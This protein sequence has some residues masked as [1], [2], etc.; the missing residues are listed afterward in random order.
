MRLRAYMRFCFIW[1]M[2]F[3]F[4]ATT[5]SQSNPPLSFRAAVNYLAGYQPMAVTVGDF[6]G[7]GK[8]DLALLSLTVGIEVTV[9]LGNGD[10]TFQSPLGY[11]GPPPG[12]PGGFAA[13]DFNGDG[14]LDLAVVSGYLSVLLGNGDGTFRAGV[15]YPDCALMSVAV[16]DFNGDGKLDLVGPDYSSDNVSV[17]M[18]NGDGTFQP[19]VNYPTFP[20]PAS[21]GVGDFNG[22]GKLD[23]AVAGGTGSVAVLLGNGDG[24]F[25]AAANYA[26]SIN[27]VIVIVG[28]FNGDGKLDLAVSD[29]YSAVG[30]LPGNGDGTFQLPPVY[31]SSNVQIR[32]AGDFNGDGKL[33]LVGL[34]P[35]SNAVSVLLGNGDGTFQ[36]AANFAVGLNPSSVAVGDFNGDGQPDLAVANE[37]GNNTVPVNPDSGT[38]SVL[39]NTTKSAARVSPASLTFADQLVGTTSSAQ[40]VTLT[41]SGGALLAIAS[42]G[43][44]LDFA[45]TN[46][47]GRTLAVG[48]QCTISVTFNPGGV[49]NRGGTLTVNDSA[50]DSPETVALSGTGAAPSATLPVGV[51]FPAQP[52]GTTSIAGGMPLSNLGTAALHISSIGI[53]GDFSQSNNCGSSVPAGGSCTINVFFKP[54]ATGTRQGTLTVIDDSNGISGSTQRATLNGTGEDFTVVSPSGSSPSQTV[55]PGQ[56]ATYT[57]NVGGEGALDQAVTFTCTGAPSESTCLVSPNAVT[58]LSSVM[59]I[60]VTVTTTAPSVSGPFSRLIPPTPPLLPRQS[61]LLMIVLVVVGLAWMVQVRRQPGVSQRSAVL[62]KLAAGLLL[63]LVMVACGGGAG[64]SGP[65]A[66]TNPG[67]PAGTYTLTVT[68]TEGSGSA[69]LSHTVTLTLNVS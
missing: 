31:T 25:Q 19:A 8:Q 23:L 35:I 7:D 47:C 60:T 5:S 27:P 48:S 67:T 69:A 20:Y 51:T 50:P 55:S 65:P 32:S 17:L 6:N 33:D 21:V 10:G 64:N 40:E 59:N 61:S 14:K 41:N 49:G 9:L 1:A 16:G 30:V 43:T 15:N 18:G 56:A 12:T 63:V 36:G 53:G 54:T 68:G 57:L 28:D 42:I 39:L 22:D 62:L 34:D 11:Y 13:G 46:T 3:C 4:V 24:T 37:W 29:G 44:D 52:V 38:V 58:L 2:Y 66:P 45:E 26:V